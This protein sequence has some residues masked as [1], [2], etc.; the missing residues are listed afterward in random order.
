MRVVVFHQGAL[1]DFLLALSAF[2]GW[3]EPRA[4]LIV[5]FWSKREH[6]SLLSGKEYLGDF[7]SLDGLLIPSLF[8]DVLWEKVPLPEFLL[9]A[10]QV[11]IFGQEG[12]RTVAE[13]LKARTGGK[14]DWLRSFPLPGCGEAHVLD[15]IHNQLARLRP[16]CRRKWGMTRVTPSLSAT[17]AAN[18]LLQGLGLKDARPV[19]VHPGSGG[20]KKIWPLKNWRNLLNWIENELSVP[21]I[22]SRGPADDRLKE[23][24]RLMTTE[25]KP[26][27]SGLPL[28]ELAAVLSL[29][30]AYI[31][32]DSGVS[33]LAAACGTPS[34]VIFGPTDP[35]VWGPKAANVYSLKRTWA[36]AE[37]FD[38]NMDVEPGEPDGEVA[39]NLRELLAGRRIK[40]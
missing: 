29:C 3:C 9:N 32:C 16:P 11:F 23:F 35:C 2:E 17:S 39:L 18:K 12:S 8:D 21:V 6:V 24:C 34:L 4:G 15:S 30:S 31:G 5:D 13:R 38:W 37:I 25:E 1:G 28:V 40:Q 22:L 14:V 7:Y 33:H 26:V 20:T 36:E 27:I 19:L 10:D